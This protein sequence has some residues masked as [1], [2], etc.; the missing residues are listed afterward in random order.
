MIF[1]KKNSQAGF[2]LMEI[3]VT[4]ALLGILS[5][6]IINQMSMVNSSKI[7]SNE[8]AIINNLTDQ[9]A[10]ALSNEKTCANPVN[11]GGQ[12]ITR[13]FVAGQALYASD[14]ITEIIKKGSTYGAHVVG[15][16]TLAASNANSVT[17]MDIKTSPN[18]TNPNEMNLQIIF[19]KRGG[20]TSGFV[21]QQAVNLPI[22]IIRD[23]TL[24]K[25]KFCFNDLTNSIASAIRLSCTGANSFYDPTANAPYGGC[26]T[27]VDGTSCPN[28]QYINQIKYDATLGVNKLVHACAPF[29][30]SCAIAGQVITSFNASGTV[31]CGWPLPNCNP[32]DL[33]MKKNTG[34][35]VCIPTGAGCAGLHAIKSFNSDGT[36]SCFKYWLP[37]TCVG[38]LM[39]SMSADGSI[40]CSDSVRPVT[41]GVGEYI[42]SFTAAGVGVCSR[43]I[44]YPFNCPANQG[45][46]GLDVN[47][48]PTCQPLTRRTSCNG[49]MSVS[50]NYINCV[51]AGGVVINPGGTNS[52]CKISAAT[53][54]GG[55]IPCQTWR[56]TTTITCTDSNSSCAYSTAGVLTSLGQ[57]FNNPVN[58]TS[59]TCNMWMRNSGPW[60]R[61]CHYVIGTGPTA[62]TP[63]S[64]VGCY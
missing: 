30:A 23:A 6:G 26:K 27:E 41:C 49:T 31:N 61:S 1:H 5:L 19:S 59:V 52:F 3:A 64:Q 51:A 25:V 63:V 9:I 12:N 47:G 21:K 22:I 60:V 37:N 17:V 8:S 33:M 53:C 7:V 54:P 56:A 44:T 14:G 43:F 46:T 36:I 15:G 62:T 39:T 42:S 20:I 34:E 48:T 16:S 10:V 28:D 13:T 38:K 55:W 50:K 32:G 24:T 29:Q 18:A 40:T 2:T 35:Y 4:G 11:F 58:P 57:A 45:I